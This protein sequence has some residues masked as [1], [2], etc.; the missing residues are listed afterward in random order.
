[1]AGL[2]LQHGESARTTLLNLNGETLM[3]L[4]EQADAI[5]RPERFADFLICV[6]VIAG[7]EL[8]SSCFDL[9][10]QQLQECR[11]MNARE[12]VQQG[13]KGKEVGEQLRIARLKKSKKAYAGS[14]NSL[15]RGRK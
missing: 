1:M 4:Y 13:F 12:I 8:D 5:R 3:E 7:D 9:A 15:T 10:N 2:V 11:T 14:S 6:S